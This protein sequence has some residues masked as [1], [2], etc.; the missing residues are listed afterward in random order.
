MRLCVENVD[1]LTIRHRTV[2]AIRQLWAVVDEV[3]PG[4]MRR[5][6]MDAQL[7]RSA[8]WALR[9]RVLIPP[10][11]GAPDV[12]LHDLMLRCVRLVPEA[13]ADEELVVRRRHLLV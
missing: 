11:L 4:E 8:R 7:R 13:G 10:R 12:W 5:H 2:D 9:H 6:G 1:S 3:L